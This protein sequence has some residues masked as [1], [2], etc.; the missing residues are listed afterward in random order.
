MKT[1][2]LKLEDNDM[3]GWTRENKRVARAARNLVDIYIWRSVPNDNVNTQQLSYQSICSV[4]CQQ[5]ANANKKQISQN[6]HV[7]FSL[8]GC[9]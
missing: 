5:D 4:L 6:S 9:L 7:T 3:I 2:M 1:A 8:P